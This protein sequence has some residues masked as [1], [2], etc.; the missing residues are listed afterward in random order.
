MITHDR[1]DSMADDLT[2]Q[3]A[4]NNFHMMIGYC[5]ADWAKVDDELFRIFRDCVGPYEQSA[6]IYY[7]TPGLNVRLELTD[8]I[9]K[10]VLPKPQKQSGDHDHPSV[11]AWKAAK[12]DFRDLLSTRRRIAHHPIKHGA[13]WPFDPALSLLLS[14]PPWFEIQIGQHEQLRSG[15]LPDLQL[16]DLKAHLSAVAALRE[17]LQHF[18][19]DVLTKRESTSCAPSLPPTS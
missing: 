4:A 18:F 9:V 19:S 1:E 3:K 16:D 10:S 11:K 5:I 8:E 7:R 13:I 6:I 14:W 2:A 17:R 12:K 15:K